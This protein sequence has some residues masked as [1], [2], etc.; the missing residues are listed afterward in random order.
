MPRKIYTYRQIWTIA[1]PILV[2][3][4][5]EQ[6]VGMTD[7]AFLGRIG[8]VE[9]GASALGG[10]FYIVAFMVGL[11]FNSGTQIIMGRRNGEGDYAEVGNVF[12]HSL[13][14]L[15]L[16]AFALFGLMYFLAP[17]ALREMI[18]SP[19]V[20]AATCDY[21][22]WR[23]YGF[24]PAY[25]AILF[26]AFYVSTTNT[27]ALTLNSLL[28]VGSNILFNYLLIFGAC[29]FPALGIAG[30]AIGSVLAECVSLLFFLLHTRRRVDCRKY[31]LSRLPRFR[32]HL[33]GRILDLSVWTMLQNVLSLA[34]WFFFFLA[35]EHLGER[36]LAATNI[37]RN[38]SS[39]LYMS[40]NALA[41]TASTL[42][43]NL[44]GQGEA[45]SVPALIWRTIHL[46][47]FLIVPCLVLIGLFPE[48]VLRVFTDDVSLI[49]A[50]VPSLYVLLTSY[51][52]TV[53]TR[54]C[55]CAVAGTGN[56]RTSLAIE[57]FCLTIYTVYILVAI[58]HF[59]APL[60]V[61]W[62]SEH[63]YHLPALLLL[64]AYLSRGSWQTKKV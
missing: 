45:A 26:R 58:F 42:V 55:L 43:S 64:W 53:P 23:I 61:C 47:F 34:T 1:Y 11:G 49:A 18:A 46:G 31:G 48:A 51:L 36:E 8:E 52:L 25:A 63:V 3:V 10:I 4:L 62:L 50:V 6:L 35:V 14:F 15:L 57:V 7:T 28:M 20:Y 54:I 12:Y 59:R 9:L 40:I 37:V 16:L 30:A 33:L 17:L 29:G 22:E 44:M 13:A 60:P 2:S 19:N 32:R 27:G 41:S 38:V 5:M 24:F 56:T 21:L 39:F